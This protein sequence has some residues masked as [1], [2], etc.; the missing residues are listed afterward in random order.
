MKVSC[1]KCG[2]EDWKMT[3]NE[4]SVRG[5]NI[6]H[7]ALKCEGCGMVYPL[8]ELAKGRGG[9]VSKDAVISMLSG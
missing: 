5:G 8:Q 3:I 2:S 1:E 4:I 6:V 7:S 9:H